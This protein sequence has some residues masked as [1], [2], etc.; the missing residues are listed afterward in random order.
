MKTF[1]VTVSVNQR[2]GNA[3]HSDLLSQ[4]KGEREKFKLIEENNVL[5]NDAFMKV[6]DGV[7]EFMNSNFPFL[8]IYRRREAPNVYFVGYISENIDSDYDKRCKAKFGVRVLQNPEVVDSI[9]L[10]ERTH[11]MQHEYSARLY[12]GYHYIMDKELDDMDEL[13]DDKYHGFLRKVLIKDF[14]H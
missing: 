8:T 12:T 4:I 11:A 6:L 5:M 9:I 3:L 2:D 13:L 14:G 10:G 7:E 1:T